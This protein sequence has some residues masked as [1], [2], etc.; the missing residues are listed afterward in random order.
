[1]CVCERVMSSI[2]VGDVAAVMSCRVGTDSA[3]REEGATPFQL[4]AVS[5]SD[6]GGGRQRG[7]HHTRQHTGQEETRRAEE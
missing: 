7:T 3:A 4:D 5:G 2:Y 6:R 1:M